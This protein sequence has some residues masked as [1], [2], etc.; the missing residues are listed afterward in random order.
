MKFHLTSPVNAADPNKVG[1][2]TNITACQ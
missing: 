2:F 1:S